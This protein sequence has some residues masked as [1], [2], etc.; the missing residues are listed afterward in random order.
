MEFSTLDIPNDAASQLRGTGYLLL[1]LPAPHRNAVQRVFTA[2][3]TFFH[4]S[5]EE[6]LASRLPQECGYRPSGIEYSQSV[7]R[8]D[9]VE[10]FTVSPRSLAHAARLPSTSAIALHQRMIVAFDMLES[11]AEAVVAKVAETIGEGA[12]ANLGGGLRLW[13]RLQVNYSRPS[14]VTAPFINELH[15]DGALV[16]LACANAAG[17][18]VRTPAG[19]LEPITAAAPE[20]LVMPGEIAWLMSGGKIPPLFHQVRPIVSVKERLSLLFFGDL[21]PTKCVPWLRN[22][23]N[24]HIDIPARVRASVTRFGLSGFDSE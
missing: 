10:S 12:P 21:D 16:T 3:K 22:E 20:I 6:K 23:V 14:A 1:S 5:V 4:L 9:Q 11:V 18:E 7:D 17:L 13:S 24:D 15:E 2:A 19:H 8:P